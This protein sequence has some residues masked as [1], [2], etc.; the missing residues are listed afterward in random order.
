MARIGSVKVESCNL[1]NRADCEAKLTLASFRARA[2]RI[3]AGNGA[4]CIAQ[5]T[6]TYLGR[7]IV[8]SRDR[9]VRIHVERAGDKGAFWKWPGARARRVEDGD[10]ALIGANV[11]MGRI[12]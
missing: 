11:S 7:V 5:E 9:P 4:I 8:I 1:P 6:V 3:E 10:H 12:G 2:R